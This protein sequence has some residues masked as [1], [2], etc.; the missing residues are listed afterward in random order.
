MAN[1]DLLEKAEENVKEKDYSGKKKKTAGSRGKLIVIT[2]LSCVLI[3]VALNSWRQIEQMNEPPEISREDL[4]ENM[5]GYLFMTVSKL[6][7]FRNSDG[8]LP[9]DEEEF[10]GWDDP[11]IEY[12]CSG[13]YF[14]ISVM[15]ADT[16]ITFE[17]GDDSSELLSED[18]LKKLGVVYN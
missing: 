5:N 16:V 12:S 17:Y 14:S 2:V 7:A 3:G 1:N 6:D 13:E 10:L 18:V 4:L 15:Y 11:V 9:M 8:R